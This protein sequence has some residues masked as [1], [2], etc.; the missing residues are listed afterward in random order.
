MKEI[1]LIALEN[2]GKISVIDLHKSASVAE[3]LEQLEKELLAFYQKGEQYVKVIYGIGVGILGKK[4]FEQIKFN[5][6]V[7][8]FS[9]GGKGYLFLEILIS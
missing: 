9:D 7:K 4:V 5:P 1:I 2:D 6:L 8:D 3:A